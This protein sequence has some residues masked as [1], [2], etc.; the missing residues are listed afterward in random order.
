MMQ[1]AHSQ[2]EQFLT[3]FHNANA[4]ITSTAFGSLPVQKVGRTFASSYDCLAE[5]VVNDERQCSVLDLGCGD[6]FLLEKLALRQQAGLS[7]QG[8]DMSPGELIAARRRLGDAVCLHEANAQ[9]LP[10]QSQSMDYVLCHL[11]IMLMD[12]V[13]LV[14][15]EIHRVL[16]VGGSFAAVIGARSPTSKPFDTYIALLTQYPKREN[17]SID[18]L[19]DPRLRT[20]QGIEDLFSGFFTQLNFE[21]IEIKRRYTPTELWSWFN[22]MYDPHMLSELHQNELRARLVADVT[23]QC[24][25]DGKLELTGLLRQFT[26][27]AV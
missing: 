27:I 22:G 26:A 24:D 16:K 5:T 15:T 4:G 2:A 6:G 14:V 13:D 10:L 17:L 3:T 19:G 8:V 23:P 18:R 20:T 11:A 1:T 9:S 21:E 12:K 7:L 25:S